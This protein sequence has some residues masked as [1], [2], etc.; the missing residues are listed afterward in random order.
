[1]AS[2]FATAN[3]PDVGKAGP[4]EARVFFNQLPTSA[5]GTLVLFESSA[6]DGQPT[7]EVRVPVKFP[8]LSAVSRF[9]YL[10]SDN[11]AS[12]A[13]TGCDV[14][15]ERKILVPSS[16]L[17]IEST[18]RA[19][20][21]LDRANIH[22]IYEGYTTAI[23]AGTRVVSVK[24]ADGVA[25]VILSSELEGYGGGSCYVAA[26]RAQIESTLKQFSSV[27]SVVISV[28]GKTPEE[29]LQP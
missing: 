9:V 15:Y 6:R 28:D 25:K 8:S 11:T 2:G 4:F 27:R 22:K 14:V 23:P 3:A 5:T 20:L 12:S 29:S 13:S 19:L 26:I 21:Q 17:P 1:M 16:S 24:V 7:H 18:L 10:L